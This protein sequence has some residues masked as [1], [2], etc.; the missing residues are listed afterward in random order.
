VLLYL[1]PLIAA[2]ELHPES[3][4]LITGLIIGGY[5][6]SSLFFN[7]LII[8]LINPNESNPDLAPGDSEAF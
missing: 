3:K 8:N 4:G 6:L 2:W 7:W 5:G 1:P